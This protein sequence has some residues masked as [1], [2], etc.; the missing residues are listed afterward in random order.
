VLADG[1]KG[2]L[3]VVLGAGLIWLVLGA[4]APPDPREERVCTTYLDG[5][6]V[7]RRVWLTWEEF[8][9]R[10]AGNGWTSIC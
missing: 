3:F 1:P 2:F 8:Q 5:D 4:W 7:H 9:R 10:R 6:G